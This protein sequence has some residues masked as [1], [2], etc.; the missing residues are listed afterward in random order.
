MKFFNPHRLFKP[1]KYF[2]DFILETV[3]IT[4]LLFGGRFAVAVLL[5]NFVVWILLNKK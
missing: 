4:A 5:M 2:I 3:I 1:D